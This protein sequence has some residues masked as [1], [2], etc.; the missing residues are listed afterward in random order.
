[1]FSC[2]KVRIYWVMGAGSF[3]CIH[4]LMQFGI[5]IWLVKIEST[6]LERAFYSLIVM[7]W[8]RWNSFSPE[9]Q[10]PDDPTSL[11]CEQS[12]IERHTF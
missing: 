8:V 11:L 3:P 1:M 12:R 4:M 9:Y 6:D 10:V 7:I 2:S 5:L